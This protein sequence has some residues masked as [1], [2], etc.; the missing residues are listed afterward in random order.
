[1]ALAIS[2][3]VYRFKFE[4]D[5]DPNYPHWYTS[6]KNGVNFTEGAGSASFEMAMAQAFADI[7]IYGFEED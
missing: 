5:D 4:R 7:E 1:M 6:T 2:G 3:D